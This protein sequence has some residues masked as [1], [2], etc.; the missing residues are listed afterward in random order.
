MKFKEYDVFI[1]GSGIAGQTV[2]KS[3]SEKGFN[4]A[5]ADNREF[6]GTCA[7]RGCDPK[8]VI[9]GIS[10]LL[11]NSKNLLNKGIVTLPNHSWDH[12][13][14]FKYEFTDAV[15]ASTEKDL[16]ALD[17]T[18]YHQSPKFID[19]HTLSVEGKTVNAKK[20]I[21][22]TGLIPRPLNIKGGDLAKLSEDF[23]ELEALPE[24]MICIGAGYIGMEF[25]HMAARFGV[26]VTVIESGDRPLS[27]FDK[28]M[29]S[30]I[31]KA[32]EALG[33]SFVFN[34]SVQSIEKL[35]KNKKN[36]PCIL[37]EP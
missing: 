36:P 5:I 14:K 2:A 22:A 13:M 12:L 33:I 28:A 25:A 8:K 3:C 20:I 11:E 16:K 6:G 9:Y 15:P 27:K 17:I 32:S 1:I 29:V 24:S 4:V 21:I 30:Y 10:E 7:N 26:D 18:L 37:I 35:R 19:K 34:A 31:V 23:L